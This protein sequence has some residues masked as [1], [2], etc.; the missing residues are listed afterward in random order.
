MSITKSFEQ[1]PNYTAGNWQKDIIVLHWWDDPSKRPGFAGTVSWL[2]DTRSQVSAHYVV[3][4]GRFTQLVLEKDMAWHAGNLAAN[5]R[6]IGIEVNPRLSD[7]DYA[8]TAYLVADI[9][10]RRGGLPLHRHREFTGT[11]CPGTLDVARVQREAEA[12]LQG[13]SPAATKP[14]VSKPKPAAKPASSGSTKPWPAG[15][16]PWPDAY[17]TVTGNRNEFQDRALF[18]LLGDAG[19]DGATLAIRLQKRLRASGDYKGSITA[20]S[21]IGPQTIQAWQRF[22]KAR[23]HYKG[24]ITA[25]SQW[26]PQTT[27]ATVNWLNQQAREYHK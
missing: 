16:G 27:R 4:G 23:G 19:Y 15:R 1:S 24:S 17:L 2:K 13:G 6:S 14:A 12:I 22:L 7:A 3:E 8:A 25:Q 9:W 21:Q 26:G 18:K 5:R 10:K 20:Q 11:A